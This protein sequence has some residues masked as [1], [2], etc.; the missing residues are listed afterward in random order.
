MTDVRFRVHRV[1][2][3][4]MPVTADPDPKRTAEAH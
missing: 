1:R 4:L 3:C 2:I